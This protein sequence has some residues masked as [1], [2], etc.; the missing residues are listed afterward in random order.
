MGCEAYGLGRTCV[1]H[2]SRSLGRMKARPL[3]LALSAGLVTTVAV[4]WAIHA[5]NVL[6][7]T[8]WYLNDDQNEGW[9]A[10]APPDWT[11]PA[12][13]ARG[14]KFGVTYIR[15]SRFPFGTKHEGPIA[16][17]NLPKDQEVVELGWPF[18]ALRVERSLH[19]GAP[20][21]WTWRRGI[22]LG[23]EPRAESAFKVLTLALIPL[24]P[25]LLAETMLFGA[26]F[27]APFAIVRL[28][29]RRQSRCVRCGHPLLTAANSCS[30]CGHMTARPSA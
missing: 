13:H 23:P 29:R 15:A 8:P 2:S 10:P 25:G 28:R 4:A 6:F 18:R 26:M 5:W 22:L 11:P 24:W 19:G 27:F 1:R 9:P 12:A 30:E 7:P 21:P 3:I 17:S 16:P 20:L 14:F